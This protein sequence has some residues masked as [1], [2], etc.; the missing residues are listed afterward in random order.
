MGSETKRA[1]WYVGGNGRDVLQ[2]DDRV[3]RGQLIATVASYIYSE[4]H[5]SQG[6]E[7]ARLIAAA[8]DLLEALKEAHATLLRAADVAEANDAPSNAVVF[9]KQADKARAALSKAEGK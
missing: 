7:T 3:D 4:G 5:T 2:Y 8:P 1:E 9:R 6:P